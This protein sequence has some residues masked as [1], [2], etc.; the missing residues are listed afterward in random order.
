MPTIGYLGP[1]G[2]HSEEAFQA[3]QGAFPSVFSQ[4][5]TPWTA[6][7]EITIAE[8]LAKLASQ[9]LD[10]IFVPSENATEGS[11]REVLDALSFQFDRPSIQ[12]EWVQPITHALIRKVSHSDGIQTVMSHPQAL[13]QS[14]ETLQ[15]K[16]K[17]IELQN[18]SST[19]QAVASLID[20]D[21]SVAALGTIS[22]ARRYGLHVLNEN[23]CDNPWNTTR[24]LLLSLND[25]LFSNCPESGPLKTALCVGLQ[26]NQAGALA[27]I[28]T[29]LAE[30][31]IDMSKIESRP[32][33]RQ[34]GEYVFYIDFMGTASPA[35][36]DALSNVT[37]FVKRLGAYPSF[38]HPK[39]GINK[40]GP[41]LNPV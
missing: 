39:L 4:A 22:A 8:L 9:K 40:I 17:H 24:F 21:D 37:G 7:A 18:S 25:A 29:L 33:K 2:S 35:F 16:F 34:L 14:R 19:S 36:Y 12:L 28:V 15:N 5:N 41:Q 20:A 27:K 3:L 1:E 26:K 38:C 30:F 31:N 23:V 13:A 6:Q 10:A 32:A 11:V